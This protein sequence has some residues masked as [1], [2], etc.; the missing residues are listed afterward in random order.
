[1]AKVEFQVKEVSDQIQ[2]NH[3]AWAATIDT[4]PREKLCDESD[5]AGSNYVSKSVY[6]REVEI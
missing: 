3:D 5:Q 6:V 4:F 1:M 2:Q